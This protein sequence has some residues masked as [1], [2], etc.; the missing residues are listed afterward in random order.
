MRELADEILVL[1]GGRI[2]ER[3]GHEELIRANGL[4][5]KL[6]NRFMENKK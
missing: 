5:A 2:T 4:Y 6:Y 3:G 1:N